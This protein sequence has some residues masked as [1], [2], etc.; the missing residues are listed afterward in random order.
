MLEKHFFEI[1]SGNNYSFL[2]WCGRMNMM[3]G[4]YTYDTTDQW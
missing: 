2:V 1:F 4:V 3:K